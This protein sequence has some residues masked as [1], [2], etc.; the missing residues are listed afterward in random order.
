MFSYLVFLRNFI[1]GD[2][3]ENLIKFKTPENF[4]F[5]EY[6]TCE[7]KEQKYSIL[8]SNKSMLT[9]ENFIYFS[10]NFHEMFFFLTQVW[11]NFFYLLRGLYS[12]QW[13][14]LFINK[15]LTPSQYT[16]IKYYIQKIFIYILFITNQNKKPQNLD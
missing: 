12:G 14:F 9:N 11:G 6:K 15:V 16:T 7:Y 2:K 8:L 13:A 5:L 10:T 1:H 3:N 4:D